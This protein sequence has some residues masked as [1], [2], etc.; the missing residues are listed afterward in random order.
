LWRAADISRAALNCE[1]DH[2]GRQ[3]PASAPN[4]INP[5]VAPPHLS[6]SGRVAIH[7]LVNRASRRS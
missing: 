2:A 7:A 3:L 6:G 1:A 5:A 4:S